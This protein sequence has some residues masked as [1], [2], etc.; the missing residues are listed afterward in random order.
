M[1][2]TGFYNRRHKRIGHLYQGRF[3][4]IVVQV[5]SCLLE[6]SR[7]VH[8]NPVRIGFM[9]RLGI[10]AQLRHLQEYRWSSLDGFLSFT[11]RKPWVVYDEVLSHV[12]GSRKSYPRFLKDGLHKGYPTPWDDL[13]GQAMLGEEGFW[14]KVKRRRVKESGALQIGKHLGDV[15][16]T[17]VSRER[18]QLREN[19]E[20][21]SKLK[22]WYRDIETRL[23]GLS[24]IRAEIAK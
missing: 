19:M 20:R 2:Y 13:R 5:D 11:K 14:E 23:T 3:K 17:L 15:D 21:D 18:R 1:S 12:G 4:A 22:K 9:K 6:L 24:Q 16:Y 8:L 7:Y 10:R